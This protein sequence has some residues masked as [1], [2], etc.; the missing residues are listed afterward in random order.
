MSN[1]LSNLD[2]YGATINSST[3]TFL[4]RAF[5]PET[6]LNRHRLDQTAEASLFQATN[7]GAKESDYFV[8]MPSQIG[9]LRPTG[10]IET[11]TLHASAGQQTERLAYYHGQIGPPLDEITATYGIAGNRLTHTNLV[12][13]GPWVEEPE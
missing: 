5:R 13:G 1:T 6:E 8:F 4:G 2:K 9:V 3:H 12:N 10:L 11:G 7:D